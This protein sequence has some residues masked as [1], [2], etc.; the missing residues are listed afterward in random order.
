MTAPDALPATVDTAP[1]RL[2]IVVRGAV[3]GVG[4]R[5]FVHRTASAL[6]LTGWVG[7]TPEGVVIEAEGARETLQALLT[8]IRTTPPPHA[9]V[10][11]VE[12]HALAAQGDSGFAVR[13]SDTQG[14]RTA[15]VQPDLATCGD[16][17]RELFDPANRRYRYPFINCT[18][19]G[20]RHS[21][22]EDLPY[23]RARTAMRQFPMCPACQA[24]YADPGDRR[25]HA[26]ATACAVCGPRLALWDA[27]GGDLARDDDALR[28]AVDALRQ[29]QI[30]AVKGIGGFHL[31]VD[32]ANEAA[33]HRL[34]VAKGR[35]EKPFAVMFPSL[36]AVAECC[37]LGPDEQALLASP[38]RPIVLL[39][40]CGGSLA[41]S[42]APDNPRIGALLPYAPVHHLLLRA[43]GAPVVAT[44]GNLRDEPIV[45]DE[46]DALVALHIADLFL[47]H[48]RP[49]VRPLEDSIAQVVCGAPQLLRRARGYGAALSVGGHLSDGIAAYGGHFKSTVALTRGG[50]VV[51]SPHLGDLVTA[52]AR[53]A[54]GRALADMMRLHAAPA[55]I[56]ARDNHPDYASSRAAAA[57]GLPVRRVQH[58]VA[59]VVA[60]MAEHEVP[61]PVLGVAWDGTGHG[62]D[63]TIWGGEFLRV[64]PDG[65]QRLGHLRPFRLPGGDAAVREPR[66]AAIGLLFAAYADD[67]FAM[68][69]LAPIAAFAPAEHEVL[70]AMLVRGINAPMTS[71]AGRLFDAF[72]ALCDLRQKSSYEGQA[73]IAL[74]WVADGGRT[75]RAYDFPLETARTAPVTID[76]RPALAAALA[77]LR[78]GVTAASISAALHNGLAN[79][80]TNVAKRSGEKRV[81]LT[82]G[83]FQ[84]VRLTEACVAA[85]R[86]AGC[87]PY[88]H[89]RL[90]P[91]DGGIAVGQAI[92]A[93]WC[94][95]PEAMSCV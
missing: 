10:V 4:F 61:S 55:C 44:S 80:I 43:F 37:R 46:R 1:R 2:R 3:Q 22:V 50:E 49:I 5:P 39:R 62:P 63:G 68:T 34:R 48:D 73:A 57:S 53:D 79:A 88:W 21:I 28:G 67:A 65:W 27:T 25:F 83:C 86:A 81:V 58:H 13:A 56:A 6:G 76:W 15:Q 29:G 8:A 33:V 24:E 23:D 69:D 84:N 14:A 74:E 89:Q 18:Q 85:L 32:A 12:T 78:A 9:D 66:R 36:G 20:P 45:T 19:C 70:R 95:A 17:L 7:N 52:R 64:T 94:E 35:E 51:L 60:C 16:C 71:S 26:E 41:P 90:P 30:V 42:V 38:A 92:W 77:D 47:V 91:N 87:V 93:S 31:V 82:G 11:A 54:H 72:A 40:R 59:H 75:D